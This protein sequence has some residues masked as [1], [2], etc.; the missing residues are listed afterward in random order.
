MENLLCVCE[1]VGLFIHLLYIPVQMNMQVE[2]KFILYSIVGDRDL[3]AIKHY[4]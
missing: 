2:D 4:P 3:V 1:C